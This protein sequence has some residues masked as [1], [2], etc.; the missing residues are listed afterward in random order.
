MN[1]VTMERSPAV[2][3]AEINSIK[4]QTRKMV[5]FN[6]IE[7]G[8]RL[9]EVKSMIP[10]GQWS[11]WLEK[12][13]DY[14][15][16]TANNLMRIY[17]EFG[18]NQLSLFSD[19]A[20]SQALGNLSY[21]QAVALLGLPRDERD[22]F[23]KENDVESMSTRELQQAIKEKQELEERLKQ[24]Q[25][26]ANFNKQLAEDADQSLND[27]TESYTE[28][29]QALLKSKKETESERQAWQ[30]VSDS[31]KRLENT[32]HEHYETAERLRKELEAAKAS[33]NTDAIKRLSESLEKAD[34]DIETAQRKIED[35]ERQLR[36]PIEVTAAP[37][38]E[39]VPEE[40]E[41]ELEELRQ[42]V[43]DLQPQRQSDPALLKFKV[44]FDSLVKG[45]DEL[46]KTLTEIS[47]QAKRETYTAA[48]NKLIGK[49]SDR[50]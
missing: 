40:V 17:E 15:Q 35:L 36:E 34:K 6:S 44:Y 27:L 37:V 45:F 16:S 33:G 4:D 3:A 32:N 11:E 1:E 30:R 18:I 50:L 9:V 47:D 5:L 31:Y 26:T 10:H 49:M 46:L 22:E 19:N 29:Q 41:R 24:A 2:I 25:E 23:L 20:N 7:I 42:K 48:V 38:I 8:H 12:S 43:Q 14:S 28:L 13:V 39:K 21:T